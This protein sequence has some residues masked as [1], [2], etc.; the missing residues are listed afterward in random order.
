MGIDVN[1]CREVSKLIG[2]KVFTSE[3][4]AYQQLGR[5]TAAGLLSVSVIFSTYV[6]NDAMIMWQPKIVEMTRDSIH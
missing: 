2:I 3:L 5:S 6:D 1:D 4:L